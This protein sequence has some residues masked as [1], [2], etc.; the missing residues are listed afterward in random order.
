MGKYDK[1]AQTILELVGGPENIESVTHCVTRLR[2]R[3]RDESKAQTEALK[4]TEGVITVMQSGGQYQVVVGQIVDSVYDAVIKA[5]HLEAIVSSTEEAA[6]EEKKSLYTRFV[7]I[8]TAV[9]TPFL[10][11]LCACGMLKG[12]CALFAQMGLLDKTGAAYLFWFNAGDALF[13][14]LPVVISYTAA[15]RFKMNE[16]TGM[17]IGLVMCAPA[18]VALSGQDVIGSVLGVDYQVSFFGIPVILPKSGN[19]T[20]SVIPAIVAVWAA[21]T[22]EHKLKKI[23]PDVIKGFMTPFLILLIIIPAMFLVIGPITNYIAVG[24]GAIT[25]AVFNI[26]P[27]LEGLML[28]A[29]WQIMVLFGMQW[30]VSPI[31]YNNFAVLGY[32]T[33]IT[34]HFAASF[35]QTAT[36]AAI[37][38]KTKDRKLKGLCTS[39]IISGIFGVTEP[40]I[41]GITLPR[42]KPFVISCI[43]SGIGG[44]I[45]GMLKVRCYSGGIGILALANYIDPETGNLTGVY[46]TVI[47]ILIAM[48]VSFVLTFLTFKDD[49]DTAATPAKSGE[50]ASAAASGGTTVLYAPLEG[51]V[52]RLDEI[53]DPVFAQEVL[54]KGCAI[55][56]SKGEVYAPFD[57]TVMLSDGMKHAVSL[58]SNQGTE[59]LIHIGMNTVELDGKF[60]TIHVQDGA[61]VQKGSLLVSFEMDAIKEH[62]Y[63]LLTPIVVTNTDAH[64]EIV[65]LEESGC[66]VNPST[67]ILQA[68]L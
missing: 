7:S 8:V 42:K 67:K 20:S 45:M 28:G 21:S 60:Y 23:L 64:Q 15:K 29:A 59:V 5:G 17:M 44:A 48:A 34:P 22:L 6:D 3:L 47:A 35:A 56:P 4:R 68:S 25:S 46:Y 39:S 18:L 13:Y 66:K 50:A 14:F 27:W 11:L 40:A 63:S 54:G 1:L 30:G 43:A 33:V 12:L 38:V 37:A 26:A 41:Y 31:R 24:L 2:F 65:M 52:L 9:F 32:D 16:L 36:V 51:T 49:V 53:E 62:G 19:Y 57:G 58:V 61:Q 55:A 10:G